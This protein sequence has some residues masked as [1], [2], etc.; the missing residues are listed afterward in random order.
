V[1]WADALRAHEEALLDGG[2]DGILNENAVRSALARPYHGYHRSIW[3]KAA[4]LMH[5][6]V[7]NHGFVDA[8]KRTSLYLAELL[9]E[10][11]GYR[12][13]E[14]DMAIVETVVAVANGTMSQ[15]ELAQWFRA[16]IVSKPR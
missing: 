9:I 14:D 10:R 1:T 8:N 11:S 13:E 3:Q 16:R 2:R 7:R 4:A 5:G 15:D 12:L 6:V